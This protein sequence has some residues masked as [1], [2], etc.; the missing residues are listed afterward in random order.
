MVFPMVFLMVSCTSPAAGSDSELQWDSPEVAKSRQ[1]QRMY[2]CI[3]IWL[4]GHTNQHLIYI[5]Y[6]YTYMDFICIYVCVCTLFK[7]L[8][9]TSHN[10]ITYLCVPYVCALNAKAHP[11]P[12]GHPIRPCHHRL[13][14]PSA[15]PARPAQ[16][17]CPNWSTTCWAANWGQPRKSCCL[18]IP[19]G[20]LSGELCW[21][22]FEQRNMKKIQIKWDVKA[23]QTYQ[24]E[25]LHGLKYLEFLNPSEES[26][27]CR[28]KS[29]VRAALWLH[30]LHPAG[31]HPRL[32]HYSVPT[33]SYHQN[34]HH[35]CRPTMTHISI[36]W[37]FQG[38]KME[39]LYHIRPYFVGIFPYIGRYLQFRFLK[40]PLIY[41][42][43]QTQ[44]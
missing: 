37:E 43:W 38:P 19:K 24:D 2:A 11:E 27:L 12:S 40:W 35:G 28:L 34:R 22:M 21:P 23:Y 10:I 39:V 31:F 41:L 25:S 9:Y 6:I 44:P 3:M 17:T 26:T 1:K 7:S 29:S 20:W 13:P 15:R 18:T 30:N 14:S 4:D 36:Q 8:Y 33:C 32:W 42:C 5:Q 16:A